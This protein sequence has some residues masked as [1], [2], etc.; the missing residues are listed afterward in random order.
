[1]HSLSGY[2]DARQLASDCD[3]DEARNTS[4]LNRKFDLSM[5]RV[6]FPRRHPSATTILAG[7]CIY[8]GTCYFLAVHSTYSARCFLWLFIEDS[9]DGRG[10]ED[11]VVVGVNVDQGSRSSYAVER[12]EFIVV[13]VGRHRTLAW[14]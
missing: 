12:S 2:P 1:M 8:R 14:S 4:S 5:Q 9:L 13:W 6:V 7:S 10:D 11:M 3:D